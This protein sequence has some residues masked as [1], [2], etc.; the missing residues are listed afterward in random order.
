MAKPHR[1]ALMT[2]TAAF[3]A[4]APAAW[5]PSFGLVDAALAV[6]VVLGLVTSL[7]RLARAGRFLRQRG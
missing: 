4:V 6:I 3:L 1:M 2:G 7:R 5:R